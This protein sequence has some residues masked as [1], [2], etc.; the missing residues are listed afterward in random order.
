M[1]RKLLWA[2]LTVVL[3]LVI[4]GGL[5]WF[6]LDSQTLGQALLTR[7]SQASGM[8]LRAGSI[9]LGIFSGIELKDVTAS[10]NYS[11]GEYTVHLTRVLFK[12]RLSSL[13]RGNIVVSE[14]ILDEP[15]VKVVIR[16]PE[17]HQT[18]NGDPPSQGLDTLPD[19][20]KL[21]VRRVTVEGG[22]MLVREELPRKSPRDQLRLDGIHLVLTNIVLDGNQAKPVSRLSGDGE[23]RI[24]RV[25]LGDL[26]LEALKGEIN[27]RRGLLSANELSLTS[28]EGDLTAGLTVD[29]N[30]TPFS[31]H[32]TVTASHLDLNKMVG[33]ESDQSLGPGRL[34][35]EGHG[36]GS[37][38]GGLIGQG[39][40]HLDPGRIPSQPI[41]VATERILGMK[42]LVGAEYEATDAHFKI[43]ESRVTIED[44]SL[45]SRQVALR[46]QGEVDLA[47]P[48]Q[49]QVRL[50]G[51][52]DDMS[53]PGVPRQVLKTLSDQEGWI[54]IPLR[55]T[56]T[57]DDPRVEPDTQ[58][59]LSEAG[60]RLLRRFGSFGNQ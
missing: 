23:I 34:D 1:K 26:P 56:G 14:A 7:A 19:S 40:V 5:A 9:D 38:P 3:L 27:L 30:P 53:V 54:V 10:G 42:G 31:Y 59:L 24:G 4:L 47:G 2:G 22:T 25:Q 45:N 36:K 52:S 39:V 55:V 28:E 44:F 58:A 50:K 17:S 35:F 49:L 57:R 33:L 51:K 41:L 20:L 18:S 48:I 13:L 21:E 37:S 15:R 46:V 8:Q 16:S 60:T 29:F 11:R 32:L 12:Y 6:V 43:A